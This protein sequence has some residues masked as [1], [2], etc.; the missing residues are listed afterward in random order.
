[1]RGVYVM[2]PTRSCSGANVS[3]DLDRNSTAAYGALER[4]TVRSS[5]GRVE[6]EVDAVRA[7]KLGR[8]SRVQF[9]QRWLA[10]GAP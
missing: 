5:D 4:R 9:D 3:A 8:L 2:V 7:R 10:A 1:V 6:A